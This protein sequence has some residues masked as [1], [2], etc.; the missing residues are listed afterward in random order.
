MYSKQ[1]GERYKLPGHQ[2]W[3]FRRVLPPGG[4]KQGPGCAERSPRAVRPLQCAPG[5]RAWEVGIFIII[6]NYYYFK[7]F[8]CIR[9]LTNFL[10]QVGAKRLILLAGACRTGGRGGDTRWGHTEPLSAP[11]NHPLHSSGG[12]P[13]GLVGLFGFVGVF[14]CWGCFFFSKYAASV[15]VIITLFYRL[16]IVC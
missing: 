7:F 5:K 4:L 6:I 14:C 2:I 10:V 9:R 13:W 8:F 16:G 11:G 15:S 12:N 1:Q 3:G